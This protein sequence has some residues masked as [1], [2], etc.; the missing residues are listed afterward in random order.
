[1]ANQRRP[2]DNLNR[3]ERDRPAAPR[4]GQALLQGIVVCGRCGRRMGLRYSGPRGNYPVY[5]CTADQ[6]QHGGARC[7]EVRALPIDAAV[8]RLAL[9]PDR[10]ALAVAAWGE[11]EEEARLLERQWP[12]RRERVHYQAERARRQYDAVEPETGWWRGRSSVPGR[13]GF[14]RS[15]KSKRNTRVGVA[16]RQP[17]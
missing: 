7:Q 13:S 8:E 16:S 6:Q 3:Y 10:R 4:K 15:S 2:A 11:F 14:A 9:A 1:M 17:C 12:L 5:Q